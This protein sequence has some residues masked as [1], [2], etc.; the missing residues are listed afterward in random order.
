[1]D[2]EAAAGAGPTHAL[3]TDL[4]EL[5]M[6]AAYDR[7]GKE[8]SAIFELFVRA[9]PQER[10]FLVVCGL[11]GALDYLERLQFTARDLE[12]LRTLELFD[13]SFIARL[14]TLRFTGDV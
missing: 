1:G 9:L 10:S 2:G 6:A 13:H 5:T 11:E 7:A 4:Y 3:L 12:Y 8:G 14:A